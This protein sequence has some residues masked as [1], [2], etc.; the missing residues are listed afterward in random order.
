M[1][2]TKGLKRDQ[3]EANDVKENASTSSFITTE[4]TGKRRKRREKREDEKEKMEGLEKKSTYLSVCYLEERERNEDGK[5]R[6]KKR[7]GKGGRGE[8]AIC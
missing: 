7:K 2:E 8:N 3:E 1:R 4:G 5:G 6:G